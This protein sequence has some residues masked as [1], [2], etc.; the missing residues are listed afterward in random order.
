MAKSVSTPVWLYGSAEGLTLAPGEGET[1]A[2]ALGLAP[3]L[4]LASGVAG[5]G[6]VLGEGGTGV[7]T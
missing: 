6:G 7:A 4:V 2:P 3:G 1:D 5:E